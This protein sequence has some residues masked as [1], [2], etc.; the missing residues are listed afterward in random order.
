MY[1]NAVSS[2]CWDGAFALATQVET[3]KLTVTQ[4][5]VPLCCPV[6]HEQESKIFLNDLF[7]LDQRKREETLL[8]TFDLA[9]SRSRIQRLREVVVGEMAVLLELTESSGDFLQFGH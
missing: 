6:L 7:I 4:E 5:R 2:Q 1:S 3:R 9:E 8:G